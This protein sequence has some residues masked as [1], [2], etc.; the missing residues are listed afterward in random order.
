MGNS[1]QVLSS[2]AEF[3]RTIHSWLPVISHRS[4]SARLVPA[5]ITSETADFCLLTLLMHLLCSKPIDGTLTEQTRSLYLL[6]KSLVGMM[7]AVGISTLEMVQARLL[8]TV[9]E[10]GHRLYP[11]T[12]ISSGAN[13]RAAMNLGVHVDENQKLL[14]IFGSGERAEEAQRTWSGVLV[15]DRLVITFIFY[16]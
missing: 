3:F 6:L 11:A 15:T 5:R 7:E 14:K 8:M 4:F 9:F 16:I 12:Y 1:H 13:L 10:V 2:A